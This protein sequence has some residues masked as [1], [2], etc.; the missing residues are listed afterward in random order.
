M[1]LSSE[2]SAQ[3]EMSRLFPSRNWIDELRNDSADL[4]DSYGTCCR[5]GYSDPI[6]S[7]LWRAYNAS[8][9]VTAWFVVIMGR[10]FKPRAGFEP[11]QA[12]WK[13]AL[14]DEILPHENRELLRGQA[15]SMGVRVLMLQ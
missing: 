5:T 9:A 12:E 13:S 15:I 4:E 6:Y 1:R 3:V 14:Q 11:A 2:Q 8:S 7:D 10:L